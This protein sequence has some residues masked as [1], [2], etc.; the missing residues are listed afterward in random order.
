MSGFL[1]LAGAAVLSGWRG[2]I[3]GTRATLVERRP[4]AI[5]EVAEM[6]TIEHASE[7]S[8]GSGKAVLLMVFGIGVMGLGGWLAVGGAERI[9]A[10][11]NLEDAAVGLTFVGLATTPELFAL[12]WA[13]AR[14]GVPE[15]C[16]GGR[17]W[18]RSLQR[19]CHTWSSCSCASCPCHRPHVCFLVCSIPSDGGGGVVLEGSAITSARLRAPRELSHFC[20]G[21]G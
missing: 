7:S 6:E 8:S 11:L 16:R 18:V 13:A 9:V 15:T 20:S 17:C 5:G 1:L 19:H 2:A 10:S 12:V 21:N 4:P 3:H 14:R